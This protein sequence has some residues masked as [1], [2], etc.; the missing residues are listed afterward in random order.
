M[1]MTP[2]AKSEESAF[3]LVRYVPDL[4]RDEVLNIGLFL[5][6]PE[7]KYLGCLVTN[8]FRR[9]KAFHPQA[10]LELLRSLQQ[11]FEEDIDQ[12]SDDWEQY[13]RS[14]REY[15]NLIQLTE[16]HSCRVRDPFA[17]IQELF[18]R[19]VGSRTGGLVL[20]TNRL[21]VKQR[22][23][24]AFVRAGVWERLEKRIFAS[25]WT[26]P[27]DT[28]AFDYGYAPPQVSGEPNGHIKFIHAL[29]Q[30]RDSKLA[31][32]LVY[33]IDRVRRKEPAQLTAVVEDVP[34]S[35]QDAL[36]TRRILAEGHV[37]IELLSGVE[38]YAQSIRRELFGSV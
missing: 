10:D 34:E 35:D 17:A 2:D 29:S 22:L 37:F 26:H 27:G 21:R 36:R 32:E 7:Q 28:F 19:Y 13:L 1:S 33:T 3:F 14:L 20:E 18:G 12:S 23:T 6:C 9:I 24:A 8:D 30:K 38:H 4:V 11:H 31:K 15:S 16:P 5:H 25:P